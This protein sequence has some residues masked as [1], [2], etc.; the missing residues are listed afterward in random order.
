MDEIIERGDPFDCDENT[1]QEDRRVRPL[2]E[3]TKRKIEQSVSLP[4]PPPPMDL[5]NL[6]G[7]TC[8]VQE[9][10]AKTIF[11][12]T[13]PSQP[14]DKEVDSP[15]LYTDKM[16]YHRAVT[17]AKQFKDAYNGLKE[18]IS[19]KLSH[20]LESSVY[21]AIMF[22]PRL[23]CQKMKKEG[24]V[25]VS[26]WSQIPFENNKGSEKIRLT[27]ITTRGDV[28]DLILY[29]T[30]SE[31]EYIKG[32]HNLFHLEK[33]VTTILLECV[34][35][36]EITRAIENYTHA[37][38]VLATPTYAGKPIREWEDLTFINFVDYLYSLHLMLEFF[39][40]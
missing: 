13:I 15:E 25:E 12:T 1:S 31:A 23:L 37:W 39:E 11:R 5:Q 36:P 24:D 9:I 2:F 40:K 33:Y 14:P 35:D 3:K 17:G 26:D 22:T 20:T 19:E 4:P 21:E 30:D 16:N 6:D 29:V 28:E 8:Y 32:L 10:I 7:F 18:R 34:K 38:T 27:F